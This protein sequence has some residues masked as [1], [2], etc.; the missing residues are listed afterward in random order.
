M[1]PQPPTGDTLH[2]VELLQPR[3]RARQRLAANADNLGKLFVGEAVRQLHPSADMAHR[4]D[5][6]KQIQTRVLNDT[7]IVPLVDTIVYNAKRAEVQGEILDAL[8]S[9]FYLKDVQLAK[10]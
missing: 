10:A 7:A 4:A 5:V 6:Y 2:Q 9:Y 1:D 3:Q 8:A